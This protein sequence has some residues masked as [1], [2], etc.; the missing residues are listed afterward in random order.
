MWRK[1]SRAGVDGVVCVMLSLARNI[2][3]RS[4]SELR[5]EVWQASFL[6]DK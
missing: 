1:S 3:S 5:V 2:S 4:S 6:P